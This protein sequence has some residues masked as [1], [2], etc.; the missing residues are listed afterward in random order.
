MPQQHR[1]QTVP[2]Y[3]PWDGVRE[4]VA[5]YTTEKKAERLVELHRAILRD[6]RHGIRS[7]IELVAAS[8]N[9]KDPAR[10]E[11]HALR[12]ARDRRGEDLESEGT[13]FDLAMFFRT[14][15]PYT[16]ARSTQK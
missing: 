9:L 10:T 2:V 14:S 1:N 11:S 7:G 12:K 15:S 3:R 5:Y 6:Q 4:R 8:G 16:W 13:R